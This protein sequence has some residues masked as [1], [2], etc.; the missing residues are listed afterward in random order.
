MRNFAL[1]DFGFAVTSTGDGTMGFLVISVCPSAIR[2]LK[3]AFTIRSS[4]LWNE[5]IAIRPPGA[6][7]ANPLMRPSRKAPSSSFTAIRSA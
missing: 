5:M 1:R 4:R 3:K 6:S 2:A 7:R